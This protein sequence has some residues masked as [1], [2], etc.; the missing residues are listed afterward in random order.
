MQNLTLAGLTIDTRQAS[1]CNY[2]HR[3][4]EPAAL[5][6]IF[7]CPDKASAVVARHH[8]EAV[9]QRHS[10]GESPT[11]FGV[12]PPKPALKRSESSI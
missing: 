4:A 5:S 2:S 10:G 8:K 9:G 12:E 6:K 7:R 3:T 11:L 1:G